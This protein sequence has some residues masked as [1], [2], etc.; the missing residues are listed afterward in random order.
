MVAVKG[1]VSGAAKGRKRLS[2]AHAQRPLF[3]CG[4]AALLDHKFGD[5]FARVLPG[6]L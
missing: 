3:A 2:A 5:E 6:C 4:E 1:L